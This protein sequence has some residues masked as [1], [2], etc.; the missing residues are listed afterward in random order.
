MRLGDRIVS[1]ARRIAP[2]GC[3]QTLPLHNW[4]TLRSHHAYLLDLLALS[5]ALGES[6]SLC[7]L[8]RGDDADGEEKNAI[9]LRGVDGR[10]VGRTVPHGTN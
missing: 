7:S 3:L 9:H 10:H 2:A 5:E 6:S 1:R 4:V 8:P